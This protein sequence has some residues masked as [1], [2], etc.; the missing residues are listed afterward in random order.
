[1]AAAAAACLHNLP[2]KAAQAI[3]QSLRG[4]L[5][6]WAEVLRV[7]GTLTVPPHVP[8]V[9]MEMMHTCSTQND[10]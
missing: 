8:N 6:M 1:M 5:H 2:S 7:R 3:S 10:E 9:S 4:V